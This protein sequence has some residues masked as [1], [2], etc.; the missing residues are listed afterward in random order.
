MNCNKRAGNMSK[1]KLTDY[2]KPGNN[3]N[4]R[5]DVDSTVQNEPIIETTTSQDKKAVT[6]EEHKP[7]HPS[8]NFCSPKMKFGERKRSFQVHW[9]RQFKGL[10]YDE[11]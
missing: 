1:R 8:D 9:F 5:K 11:Q 4:V 2:F 10:H 3:K 7:F 6:M